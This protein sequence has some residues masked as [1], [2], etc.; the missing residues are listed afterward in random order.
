MPPQV[1]P[2]QFAQLNLKLS[3]RIGA[4]LVA[5]S[6]G[7]TGLHFVKKEYRETLTF[8]VTALATSAAGASA[9]YALRSI[10]QNAE[11]QELDRQ[12]NAAAQELDRQQRIVAQELDRQQTKESQLIDR[13]LLYV[14]RWNDSQ[15]WPARKIAQEFHKLRGNQSLNN[16]KQFVID[17]VAHNPE[18]NQDII[19]L[20]NFLEDM[21]ICIKK[22]I[23]K[24]EL[25][26]DY[27]RFI[28]IDFYETFYD[29]IQ[30][31][32]TERNNKKIFQS[33]TDLSE[34]WRNS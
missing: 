6:L 19:N 33:L 12:Q 25:L 17:Y 28:V 14:A 5:L 2:D 24:E 27:Y 20:L 8:L 7:L 23:V 9:V 29:F 32:R 15:Y 18:A 3:L 34:K 30:Q 16:Q 13:T 21:A 10:K 26:Y 1:D 31:R 4:T 22:G 11:F